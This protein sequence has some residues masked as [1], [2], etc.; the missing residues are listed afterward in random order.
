MKTIPV[1][2]LYT[3]ACLPA[4][5]QECTHMSTYRSHQHTPVPVQTCTHM[6]TWRPHTHAHP[7]KCA[8]THAYFI[9][10]HLHLCKHAHTRI[11]T[12]LTGTHLHLCKYAHAVHLQTSQ[13]HTHTKL[14]I[15]TFSGLEPW[16]SDPKACPVLFKGPDFSS[17]HSGGEGCNCLGLQLR[18]FW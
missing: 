7:H 17:Q 9:G 5:T 18:G 10:T 12:V 13:T 3:P 2:V 4:S 1:I 15:T 16:L 11:L 8:H 14:S 6:H